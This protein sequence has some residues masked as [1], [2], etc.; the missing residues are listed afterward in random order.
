MIPQ[1]K[2]R[3]GTLGQ[4]ISSEHEQPPAN[5]MQSKP[6]HPKINRNRPYRIENGHRL[7]SSS[8]NLSYNG[9]MFNTLE[10][11]ACNA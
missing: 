3:A 10:Y 11:M 4:K 2:E 5:E 9:F 7:T 6:R 8:V 1:E